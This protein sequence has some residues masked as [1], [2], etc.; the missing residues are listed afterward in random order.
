MAQLVHQK[1]WTIVTARLAVCP[2]APFEVTFAVTAEKNIFETW[3]S[4]LEALW[5]STYESCG[6]H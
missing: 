6:D 3:D 4:F 2:G 5:T 1:T